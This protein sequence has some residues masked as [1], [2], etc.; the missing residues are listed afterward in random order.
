MKTYTVKSSEVTRQWY[1]VDASS[2]TLGRLATIIAT[3]LMGKHKPMYT[4]HIDCGDSIIVINA[5]NIKVT[6]NRLEDK[7][8][9]RHSGY[10]GGL[11]T[12]TL[13]Q[14]LEKDP[15]KVVV[16]AVKGMLPKNKLSAARLTRLKVYPTSDHP[17][18]PQQ[19]K[20]LPLSPGGKA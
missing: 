19:P 6:G 10:P 17:H 16:H 14:Q 4:P 2:I 18:A 8:Y 15:T 1:I 13:A 20:E 7:K 5:A 12:I 9:Y 11:T 3:Y